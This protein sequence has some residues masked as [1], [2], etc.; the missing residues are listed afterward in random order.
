[1]GSENYGFGLSD[2][3]T[4]YEVELDSLDATASGNSQEQKTDWPLFL[5]GGKTPLTNVAAV[6][7][8]EVQIPFTWYVFNN[9]NTD[10]SANNPARW[11]LTQFPGAV[12]YFPKLAVG[13]YAGGSNFATALQSAINTAVGGTPYTVTYSDIT[14]KLT[15]T[16]SDL[17]VTSFSFTFGTLTNSGNKNIR[18]FAGFP[19]GTT[20][21]TVR[22]LVSPNA[23][24]ISGP[25]Y[26]YVNSL[27]IGNL[28]NVYLPQ[29]AENLG[30]GNG[31]PQMA[32]VPVNC[33]SGETIF[34]QDPD[35]QK[36]FDLENLAVLNQI[37]LFLTLGNLTT[38]I[39][40]RLNGLGFSVKL[41]VLTT[42]LS[43]TKTVDK[44]SKRIRQN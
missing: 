44:V 20:T 2:A 18:L 12:T 9:E 39:P 37:D 4:Y 23:L 3:L 30:G 38:Q 11:I 41:G 1:M 7:I 31:G 6:K 10:N 35:P 29:G 34:W 24:L 27:S 36:W 28:T 40:L 21:S 17:A 15:F 14:Q 8:L 5:L 26:L 43:N 13:N 16:T 19:G 42:N 22:T 25:N 32:R 33:S